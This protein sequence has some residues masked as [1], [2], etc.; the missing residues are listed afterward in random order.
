MVGDWGKIDAWSH[1]SG[2]LGWSTVNFERQ[3]G[4]LNVTS[5]AWAE[6]C[7]DRGL[8]GSVFEGVFD[9]ERHFSMDVSER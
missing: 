5:R 4:R 7:F 2:L 8:V 9:V 3:S 6:R 1:D